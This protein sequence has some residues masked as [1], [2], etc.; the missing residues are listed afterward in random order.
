MQLKMEVLV[1]TMHREDHS[2]LSKMGINTDAIIVNQCDKDSVEEFD[3]NGHKIKWINSRERGLSNSRNMAISYATND[4]CLICDDDEVL[5]ND[6]EKI[7]TAAFAKVINADI[8][9]FNI[10]RINWNEEEHLFE[11][12]KR[13]SKRKT[14]SSVH[15]AFKRT[16]IAKAGICFNCLFGAGSGKYLCA[17]DA[18]FCMACHEKKLRMYT[19]PAV[20]G[21]VYCEQSTWFKG[22]NE[23]YFYDTGAFLAEA[24]P[25]TKHLVKWYYPFRCRKISRLSVKHIIRCINNGIIGYKS[26][27]SFEEY[28][29]DK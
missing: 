16:A 1:S 26:R 20:I 4:I 22:Y 18:L 21:D 5:H 7:I 17:E 8:L 19:F 15:I 9:I 27:K 14:Y 2:L 13:V 25:L 10:N 6:Y 28:S 29:R 11:T 12:V 24:Y 3:Y 23:Q